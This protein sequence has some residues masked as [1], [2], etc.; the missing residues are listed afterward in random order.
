MKTK[1]VLFTV[2]LAVSVL[3]GIQAVEVVDANPFMSYKNIEPITGTLPPAITII[4]PLNNTTYSPESVVIKFNVNKPQLAKSFT[5]ITEVYYSIDNSEE[6]EVY[7]QYVNGTGTMGVPEYNTTFTLPS[8]PMGTH[9]LTVK[10]IGAVIYQ[11][12]IFF[13][14]SDATTSFI[15]SK[16]ILQPA[17]TNQ[18]MPTINTGPTLPVELNSPVIYIILAIVIVIIAVASTSLVY[19][20]KHKFNTE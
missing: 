10:A 14:E 16:Q 4:S 17:S 20:K 7:S 6:V 3:I 13:M 12:G 5:S 8:L 15:V 9:F 18:S 11:G 2:V 1:C 19:F